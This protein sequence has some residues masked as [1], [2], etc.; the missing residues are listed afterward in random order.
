MP[1]VSLR[2][3]QGYS[4]RIEVFLQYPSDLLTSSGFPGD[5]LESLRV[6]PR[7]SSRPAEDIFRLPSTDFRRIYLGILKEFPQHSLGVRSVFLRT[8]MGYA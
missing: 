5:L 4:P 3:S 2:D 1:F 7:Y 6:P 8:P